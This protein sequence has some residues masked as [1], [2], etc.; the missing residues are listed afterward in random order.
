[1]AK[2]TWSVG[3]SV[4]GKLPVWAPLI[5]VVG[6]LTD[7]FMWMYEVVLDDGRSLHAY[8]HRETRR[9][10]HLDTQ[11]N[12]WVYQRRQGCSMYRKGDLADALIEAFADW[13]CLAFGPTTEERALVAKVIRAARNP[14][15]RSMTEPER[16]LASDLFALTNSLRADDVFADELYCALCNSDWLHDDGTEWSGSWRYS[17][18]VVAD[19]RELRECYLDFYC[20]PTQAEGTISD[21]VATALA[22]LGW[23][24]TGHGRGRRLMDFGTGE[25]KVWRD[26]EWVDADDDTN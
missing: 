8:K 25:R 13:E 1:M 17:A 11:C 9:Y 23:H 24:G 21:R 4:G 18:G 19:L 12:L 14:G 15:G 22:E 20:S 2:T 3:R 10:L 7:G 16:T 6:A 5:A 26:G